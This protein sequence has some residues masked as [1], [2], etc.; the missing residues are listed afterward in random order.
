[1]EHDDD[2]GSEEEVKRT[3]SKRKPGQRLQSRKKQIEDLVSRNN[4]RKKFEEQELNSDSDDEEF[5]Y[6]RNVRRKPSRRHGVK[7]DHDG[8]KQGFHFLSLLKTNMTVIVMII[9]TVV[10]IAFFIF[11]SRKSSSKQ[12]ANNNK[13]ISETPKVKYIDKESGKEISVKLVK[14]RLYEEDNE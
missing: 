10:I 13:K 6:K 1:M 12:E 14:A 11:R 2:S 5:E 9:L 3:R 7:E 4:R 8:E